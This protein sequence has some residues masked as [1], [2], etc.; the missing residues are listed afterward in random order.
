MDQTT[1]AHA[2]HEDGIA[3]ALA[4]FA[5]GMTLDDV[6]DEVRQRAK[7]L[8]LDAL[9]LAY[10]TKRY[11]F[12]KVTLAAMQ[13]LGSGSSTV[14]GHG[15]LLQARDAMVMNGL[16]VHGLDF[17]DTHMGGVIHATASLFPCTLGTAELQGASGAQVLAAYIAGVEVGA[18]LTSAGKGGFHEVGFNP[19]GV[20]GTFASA[21]AASRLAGL[22]PQQA[23]MA[24]GIALSMASGSQAFLQGGAWSKRIQ[25]GWAAAA[26][27]TAATLAKHGFIGPKAPYEGRFGLFTSYLGETRAAADLALATSE[28]GQTWQ[29]MEVA[30]KPIPACVF[31]HAAIDAAIMLHGQW[32]RERDERGAAAI[33]AVKRVRVKVP[34]EVVKTVCEPV[35]A[36]RRPAN[37]Y[38]AQFSIPY[39][40][41]TGLLKGAFTLRELDDDAVADPQV[42]ALATK[43]DYE[44][45]PDTT[46]PRHHTGE[47]IVEFADGRRLAHRESVNRGSADRPLGNDEVAE[48]YWSN[49]S[50][51]LSPAQASRIHDAVLAID[52]QPLG[53]LLKLLAEPV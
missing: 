40:V 23:W 50:G 3:A 17:D 28:L 19:T 1:N 6:P 41:A 38:E 14:I 36:K 49:V 13:S 8:M 42:L 11:P 48:K 32:Q 39:V 5:I 21:V 24:Q 15:R 37:A 9:G 52:R 27:M 18:R 45:D 46:F 12:T 4:N 20:I 53:D 47:V 44:V 43:V 7:Y 29:T 10:A 2:A 33:E 51:V 31:A 22:T 34:R 16:L 25:P 35:E 30:V 26:G